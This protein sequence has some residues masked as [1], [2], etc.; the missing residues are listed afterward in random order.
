MVFEDISSSSPRP[1]TNTVKKVSRKTKKLADNYGNSAF[2][3]IDRI[4]KTISFVVAIAL[5]LIFTG[6][7]VLL[8]FL[9]SSF[10]LLSALVLLIGTAISFISL[11]IIYGIGHII[12]QNNEILRKLRF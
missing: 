7:A 4:I 9:D 3:N 2:K 10:I 11:F 5:F 8:Y 6:I 12:T 1:I